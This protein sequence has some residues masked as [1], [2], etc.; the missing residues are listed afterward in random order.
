MVR[1]FVVA[2]QD[3]VGVQ[4]AGPEPEDEG[5]ECPPPRFETGE[6]VE[7][8]LYPVDSS[9]AGQTGVVDDLRGRYGRRG[10]EGS[11]GS[12]LATPGEYLYVIDLDAPPPRKPKKIS[13]RE[14]GLRPL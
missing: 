4:Q 8:L 3:A 9:L 5:K 2:V 14:S 6:K 10:A 7:V 11:T 12:M 13:V 1:V